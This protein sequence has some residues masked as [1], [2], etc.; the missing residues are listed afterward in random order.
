MNNKIAFP[1]LASLLADSSGRSKR[2]SEDF[3]R[4]FFA[5]ISE[6]LEAGNSVKVKG[7]GTFR[8]ARVEPRKSVDVTTGQPMEISGH[9]KVVF[10]PAKEL[11]EAVNA[12]FEAFS[13]IEIA[14]DVDISNLVDDEDILI[15]D[16][17]REDILLAGMEQDADSDAD[18]GEAVAFMPELCPDKENPSGMDTLPGVDDCA[19]VGQSSMTDLRQGEEDCPLAADDLSGGF[20]NA[21]ADE[22]SCESA[23]PA[24]EEAGGEA[25]PVSMLS[26]VND[27]VGQDSGDDAG[28]LVLDQQ[29]DEVKSCNSGRGVSDG[30][31]QS[32]K[33]S[34]WPVKLILCAGC[35]LLAVV[36]AIA[37]WMFVGNTDSVVNGQEN[38]GSSELIAVKDESVEGAGIVQAADSASVPDAAGESAAEQ[39]QCDEPV[40]TAPSDRVVYDTIGTAR[41]LTTMAK[42]HYG[43]NKFWP[44]IYEENKDRIGHP[45]RIR[46][47]T[48]IV[49][50]ELS[51]YGVDPKNPRDVDKAV[52]LGREIYARYGK[53]I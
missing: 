26:D 47:G 2:F 42:S 27:T 51:K 34:G 4:E 53:I 12:P 3:L 8:L 37:A 32:G 18:P 11:A 52:N 23:S 41:Y 29:E 46:P 21:L 15:Q 40:P 19:G 1:K 39:I 22:Y 31:R 9:S 48:P 5:L 25:V 13:A 6:S 44:Y 33:K 36:L 50:P 49:I 45:D 10:I 43:N 35:A 16:D 20:S 17:L 7:L 14:D 38:G 24:S 30:D 28:S